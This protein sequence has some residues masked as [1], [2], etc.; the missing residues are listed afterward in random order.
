MAD[1]DQLF[2]IVAIG[3]SAGGLEAISTFLENVPPDL[4]MAYV[5]IQHL[6]PT[7]ESI[8]PEILE[9]K[10][11][12]K[13]YQVTNGIGVQPDSVYV[14]PPNAYMR[15]VDHRLTL[16]AV[17]KHR[18]GI[19]SID[20]FLCSLAPIY[21]NNAIAVILSGTASDG[22]EGIR[23]MWQS[24]KPEAAHLIRRRWIKYPPID[25][26]NILSGKTASSRS[27]SLLGIFA[28]LPPTIS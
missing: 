21:Q 12:M 20:Y 27:L 9:R 1:N 28:F 6:S 16:S 11:S 24:K 15:I 5:I 3:A 26:K 4:G 10:T 7:H 14:I 25:W 18:T 19:H 2:P 8:L 22:T 17:E 23:A 13:V